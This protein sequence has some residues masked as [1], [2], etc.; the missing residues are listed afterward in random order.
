V[1]MDQIMVD[2]T[3]I[4]DVAVGDHAVILGKSEN[5]CITAEML[6]EMSYSFN[7]EV[8]CNFMPRVTRVYYQNG[9]LA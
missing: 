1:C 5:A 2:V 3:D 9:K 7:Y 6:G 8:V 4:A